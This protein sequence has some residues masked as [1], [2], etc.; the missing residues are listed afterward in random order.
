MYL[1]NTLQN[2]LAGNEPKMI[3]VSK[4]YCNSLE[5]LIFLKKIKLPEKAWL[6][7]YEISSVT[8]SRRNTFLRGE[9]FC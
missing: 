4:L 7:K 5:A 9:G 3:P 6:S 1:A 8:S 2:L